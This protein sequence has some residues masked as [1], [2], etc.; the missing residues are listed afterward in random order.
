MQT[1]TINWNQLEI[2]I[3]FHPNRFAGHDHLELETLPKNGGKRPAL[4][5]T[6]TGYKSHFAPHGEI[7]AGGGAVQYVL[8]ALTKAEQSLEWQRYLAASQQLSLF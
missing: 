4:P 1:F 2:R 6:E 7:E 8:D 5:L 3:R